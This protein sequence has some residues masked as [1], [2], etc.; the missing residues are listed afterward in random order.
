MILNNLPSVVEN[1]NEII[2]QIEENGGYRGEEKLKCFNS[3]RMDKIVV[4]SDLILKKYLEHNYTYNTHLMPNCLP[5]VGV[6][7]GDFIEHEGKNYLTIESNV[8]MANIAGLHYVRRCEPLYVEWH[9]KKEE[10]KKR[11]QEFLLHVRTFHNGCFSIEDFQNSSGLESC[12]GWNYLGTPSAS[13]VAVLAKFS[14]AMSRKKKKGT[15]FLAREAS[16]LAEELTPYS[17][18]EKIMHNLRKDTHHK[19]I[20]IIEDG[21]LKFGTPAASGGANWHARADNNSAEVIPNHN[22]LFLVATQAGNTFMDYL[23]GAGHKSGQHGF[24]FVP[25]NPFF[26]L[27][28]EKINASKELVDLQCKVLDWDSADKCFEL[29]SEWTKAT[30]PIKQ[31]VIREVVP[32]IVTEQVLGFY[33]DMTSEK[34]IALVSPIISES[35]LAEKGDFGFPVFKQKY[36]DLLF[37]FSE[38]YGKSPSV[39]F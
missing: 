35:H 24:M 3:A 13:F 32:K 31:E 9:N 5:G 6:S 30:T 39:F 37:E 33:V 36:A 22:N 28:Q 11:V 21:M 23:Y 25:R 14:K 4:F 10:I 19:G 27:A 20:P 7:I 18:L 34:M 12:V 38:G 29:S 2:R 15:S 1:K 8:L 17:A 16:I 26:Q